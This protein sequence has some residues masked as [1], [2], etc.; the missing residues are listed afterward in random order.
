MDPFVPGFGGWI[1]FLARIAE[2]LAEIFVPP[3]I[4]GTKIPVPD[5]VVG[6]AHRHVKAL[7]AL[8]QCRLRGDPLADIPRDGG[9]DISVP[10]A[11]HPPR[12]FE[13]QQGSVL[14]SVM[15][16]H[17]AGE[18]RIGNQLVIGALKLRA[19]HGKH[20]MRT[21][22]E[23]LLPR[24]AEQVACRRVDVQE[25]HG[26]TVDQQDHVGRIVHGEPEP[27]QLLF[28]LFLQSEQPLFALQVDHPSHSCDS[29]IKPDVPNNNSSTAWSPWAKLSLGRN[30]S[31]PAAIAPMR[32]SSLSSSVIIT[33][34]GAASR[35]LSRE[36]TANPFMPGMLMSMNMRSGRSLLV[37]ASASP[38]EFALAS[39]SKLPLQAR[40][41]A[42]AL[43]NCK[44]SSTTMT[45]MRFNVPP[46][47]T[48]A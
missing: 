39:T 22:L 34:F 17:P 1:D 9:N 8:A 16:L 40:N 25:A 3:E 24:I 48:R 38:A 13:G 43:A 7:V 6:C 2:H 42:T 46:L 15:G 47:E 41:C 19:A 29:L 14:A 20:L 35:P 10:R 45:L 21:H 26:G 12:R 18:G 44:L 33:I 30:A 23:H 11:Q 37:R 36:A 28:A 4:V 32:C 5:D 27:A 31:A